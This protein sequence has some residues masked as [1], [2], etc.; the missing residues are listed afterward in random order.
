[1]DATDLIGLDEAYVSK[2]GYPNWNPEC[3]FN[4]DG[5][6]DASD[7]FDLGK[8]YGKSSP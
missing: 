1:M 6:V 7:L 8:N 4:R 5:K 2:L 3:D